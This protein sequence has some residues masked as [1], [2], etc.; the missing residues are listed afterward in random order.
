[1]KKPLESPSTRLLQGIWSS[2]HFTPTMPPVPFRAS[3]ILALTQKQSH[4]RLP[5]RW[6]N[7]LSENC[8]K[9]ARKKGQFQKQTKN[10][11]DQF[12]KRCQRPFLFL[13]KRNIGSRKGAI[14]AIISV[15]RAAPACLR[16]FLLTA[17]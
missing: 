2:P 10:A 11:L 13:K 3:L 4:R 7:D 6:R 1:M 14:S 15:T 8:A 16:E 17:K 5:S 9:S 12:L